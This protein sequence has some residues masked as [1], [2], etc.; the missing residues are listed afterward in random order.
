M[1]AFPWN[2]NNF[3]V[4][5]FLLIN[6]TI[7]NRIYSHKIIYNISHHHLFLHKNNIFHNNFHYYIVNLWEKKKK[8]FAKSL[9]S[10]EWIDDRFAR[11]KFCVIALFGIQCFYYNFFIHVWLFDPFNNKKIMKQFLSH[12]KKQSINESYKKK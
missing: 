6:L 10:N 11:C 4:E 12:T 7:P 9:D 5:K 3:N 8:R 1:I 2:F